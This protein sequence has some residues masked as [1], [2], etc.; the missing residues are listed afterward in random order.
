MKKLKNVSFLVHINNEVRGS[1][2]SC[3]GIT[4]SNY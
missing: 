1:K 4:S 3:K 2:D